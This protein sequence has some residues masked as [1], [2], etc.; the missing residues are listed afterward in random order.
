[1]STWLLLPALALIAGI[2]A[3][4]P[5][6]SQVLKRG[7]VF[8]DLAVAQAAAA[9]VIWVH[10][11]LDVDSLI[12]DQVAATT[13][14]VVA[15]LS[16]AWVARHWSR[17]REALIGLIYVAGACLA[18]LGSSQHPHGREKLFQLLA[19]DVLWVDAYSVGVLLLSALC[20]LALR[21]APWLERDAIFYA[22]FAVVASLAVPALGLFLV[23]ASLIAPALWIERGVRPWI[24]M[25]MAS[26]V[27]LLGL[28]ASWMLD[29]PSGPTLVLMLAAFGV[30]ALFR[31]QGKGNGLADQTL[32]ECKPPTSPK[33]GP[34]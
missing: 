27:C 2:V 4:T 13:G 21:R 25:A 9:A 22:A 26:V 3:L 33:K 8:I 15:S 34:A 17:Q 6:G 24:A 16:I 7:V 12:L 14:A 20:V 19:A 18:L 10:F 23:F 31:G 28:S 11:V 32:S 29:T 5:L 30:G 1:M